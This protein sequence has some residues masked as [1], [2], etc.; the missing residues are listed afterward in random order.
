M[1]IKENNKE[2]LELNEK[3]YEIGYLLV[4]SLTE[5]EATEFYSSFKGL[6]SNHNGEFISDEIPKMIDLSYTI[7]KKI[8]NK[9][10]KFNNAYF[11]W[12]KFQMSTGEILKF[13]KE[14]DLEEKIIRFLI[15]KTVRENTIAPKKLVSKE[16]GIKKKVFQAKKEE[17]EV[18]KAPINE[19]QI[20][21]EIE[22]ML[23]E[24]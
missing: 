7:I 13:K 17:D 20:D 22:K 23:K 24:E 12:V 10:T 4:P 6:I 18:E 16:G 2:D 9:N 11:S 14:L 3:V 15:I 8:K 5:E 1:K 19:D 21:S